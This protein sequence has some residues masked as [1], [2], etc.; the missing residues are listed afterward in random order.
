MACLL[1]PLVIA[2]VL[3]G[4]AALIISIIAF[5]KIREMR[6]HLDGK[7]VSPKRAP[8]IKPP[9][10]QPLLSKPL[11]APEKPKQPPEAEPKR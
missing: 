6:D 11:W 4:P 3:S 10:E 8:E 9:A 5:T 7:T 2:C 1:V